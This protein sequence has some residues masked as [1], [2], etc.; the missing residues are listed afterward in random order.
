MQISFTPVDYSNIEHCEYICHWH[1]DSSI[2]YLTTPNIKEGPIPLRSPN[3]FLLT[4]DS[5][6]DDLYSFFI[7]CNGE[8]IGEISIE[9]DPKQL[10]K[11]IPD[12]GW[13]SILIGN[14]R[15]RNS[16]IG[17]IAMQFIED[18][19]DKIGLKRIELGVF[20]FNTNAINFYT[21]LGYTKFKS[22]KNLTFYNG[23]WRDDYRFEKFL[24]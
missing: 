10:A 3:D 2:N 17:T 12:S 22:V 13:L 7:V 19:A 6:Y 23:L 20:E 11:K 21:K 15:Y 24:K 4:K 1:N 8:F 14:N 18:F 16:G 5:C 9:V